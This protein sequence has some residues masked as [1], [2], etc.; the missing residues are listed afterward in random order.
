MQ[1]CDTITSLNYVFSQ[2]CST[3]I[4]RTDYGVMGGAAVIIQMG[5]DGGNGP[6]Q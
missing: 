6:G 4:S 2:D 3:A 5:S 1:R